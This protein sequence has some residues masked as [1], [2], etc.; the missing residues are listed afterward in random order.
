MNNITS[1]EIGANIKT[2]TN[3]R[4]PDHLLEFYTFMNNKSNMPISPHQ[5]PSV[6]QGSKKPEVSRQPS[7]NTFT[8]FMPSVMNLPNIVTYKDFEVF[9]STYQEMLD[10]ADKFQKALMIVSNAAN[11]FGQALENTIDMN[12]KVNNAKKVSDGLINAGSLQ[13]IVGSNHQ[14]LSRLL[15]TNFIEPLQHELNNLK[16]D[17]KSNH[18]YHQREVKNKSKILR[19]KE[20][21]NLS[22]SKLRTRNLTVYKNNLI[23][24]T[25][26]LDE[27]DRLKYDYYHEVNIMIESFNENQLLIKTGSIIRAELELFEG[28]ARKGWSGGGLDRLLEISPDLFAINENNTNTNNDTHFEAETN[29]GV[30]N[31]EEDDEIK[32]QDELH[33]EADASLGTIR[34]YKETSSDVESIKDVSTPKVGANTIGSIKELNLDESFSLPMINGSTWTNQGKEEIDK[35]N[36]L[37]E[38]DKSISK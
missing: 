29:F 35:D 22:L 12:P 4:P 8:S 5:S 30:E 13:Y 25:N 27:I 33:D 26:Q 17:Y 24:L 31:I 21:E 28:I 6:Y 20:L 3:T 7:L 15:T 23:N 16:D 11:E 1:P 18:D 14:I 19:A 37:E 10:K 32:D 9:V 36:L 34:Q 38:L 2:D